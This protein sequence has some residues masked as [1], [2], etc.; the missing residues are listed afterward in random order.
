[1]AD[2][3]KKKYTIIK[4]VDREGYESAKIYPKYL[5]NNDNDLVHIEELTEEEAIKIAI[6]NSRTTEEEWYVLK[7][8]IAT[9]GIITQGGVNDSKGILVENTKQSDTSIKDVELL[10]IYKYGKKILTKE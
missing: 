8:T 3:E 7:I 9:K 2:T 10:F 5:F 6:E 1:M 4:V